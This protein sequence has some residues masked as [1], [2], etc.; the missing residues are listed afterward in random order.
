NT[1]SIANV[2]IDYST[3][4]GGSWNSITT[5]TA[6]NGVFNWSVPNSPSTTSLVRI[7]DVDGPATDNSNAAFTIAEQRT[8]TLTSPNGGENW[9]GTT[10]QNIT[11]TNTGSIANVAIDY[12]TDNGG[13]WNSITTSSA[14]NGVFNWS[15][16][17]SPSTTCLVKVSDIDGPATDNSNAVF[18]IAEQRTLTLTAPNGGENWEGATTQNI[19]WTHTGSIANVAIDYSTDNGGTWNSITTTT[20]NS[21]SFSWPVPNSPSTT[22]LVRISDVDGPATDNSNAAFTI[23]EQRTLTLTAPNG[24]ENWE[25]ATTQNITWTH[26]GSIAN[27]AIDYSTD[28]GGSWNSI[29]TSTA[30][31]GTFNW[32][33]PNSPS[34][35][36]LVR[37]S[38]IDGPATDNSNAVF[39]IAEQRTLTLTAPN[40]GENW[41]GAANQ[42]ITWTATGGIDNVS[43][44]YSLDNG[45][46]WNTITAST[47][48]DGSFDWTV[49]NFPSTTCLIRIT[50]INGP[51]TDTSNATFTIL[52][53]RTLTV[54]A[55]NG[56][57]DLEALTNQTIGWKSTGDIPNV[58]IRYSTDNGGNWTTITASTAN[59]GIYTWPVPNSPSTTCLV[60]IDGALSSITDS[61]DATFTISEPKSITVN[62]PNGGQYFEAGTTQLISWAYTGT[63]PTVDLHFSSDNGSTWVPISTGY[64]NSGTYS[65]TVPGVDSIACLVRVGAGTV[66]DSSNSVFTIWQQPSLT[67]ISP[68]G[69]EVWNSGSTYTITWAST[70]AVG[71]VKIRYSTNGGGSYKNI[72]RRT[73]DDG[74]YQWTVPNVSSS[75]CKIK[76]VAKNKSC[77]DFSDSVFTIL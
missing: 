48:N 44:E 57:E 1:G 32:P 20:A 60:K 74:S 71:D 24:G 67:I 29:T 61:S 68:N 3:D 23:A 43:I 55:P 6:N 8:L 26:T 39:T 50:D 66:T 36:S 12:S 28:N 30:N 64:T 19:T 22:S 70:G 56:G 76:I 7:S 16:P 77:K 2:A 37:I 49:P 21:G 51:A 69:G 31:S 27:V 52:E 25:G 46:T 17:N 34:T 11:W 65:W 18:T 54:I 45:A 58:A 33:V 75:L 73:A 35:T 59:D 72:T 53:Q 4:N 62:A 13:S 40:G 41:E 5:S 38:D 42:I 15:V 9:E 14:N 47:A 10:N 63:M